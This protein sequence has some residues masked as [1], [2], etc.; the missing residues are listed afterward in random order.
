MTE[1]ITIR[2][3]SINAS[4]N[5]ADLTDNP[6]CTLK[7]YLKTKIGN[8]YEFIESGESSLIIGFIKSIDLHK[9]ETLNRIADEL[10]PV[11]KYISRKI[12]GPEY[13]PVPIIL[14]G[15]ENIIE[16]YP[17]TINKTQR[18]E[19]TQLNKKRLK[20]L[21]LDPR[22][23][24]WDSSIWNRY[25]P[26]GITDELAKTFM[27]RFFKIL[28]ETI[29]N[30]NNG[31]YKTVVAREFLELQTRLMLNSYLTSVKK[32][33]HAESV[34]PFAFHSETQ[35]QQKTKDKLGDIKE[36]I[37]DIEWPSTA[38]SI[39]NWEWNFLLV[40]DYGKSGLIC[41]DDSKS[42]NKNEIIS[43]LIDDYLSVKDK[44]GKLLL[45]IEATIT[46]I[47]N[48]EN[49]RDGRSFT[50]DFENYYTDTTEESGKMYDIIL[51]DY[52]LNEPN[53]PNSL[54]NREFGS[55][56]LE[57]I[58]ENKNIKEN[59]GPHGK[60]WIF[61]I[62]V[63]SHAMT[64]EL[65][66]KGI[67]YHQEYWKL[68]SGADP[69]NMPCLFTYKLFSFMH[70]Q[71]LSVPNLFL[72]VC[73]EMGDAQKDISIAAKKFYPKFV[74][75]HTAYDTLRK[76]KIKRSAFAESLYD[77][78]NKITAGKSLSPQFYD[79]LL[80]LILLV[81]H[82]SGA[83][84]N[85]MWEEYSFIKD[86]LGDQKFPKYQLGK[87]KKEVSVEALLKKIVEYIVDINP[88]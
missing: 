72:K 32:G 87:K 34:I 82:G 37:K 83:E 76:D 3:C 5:T 48:T 40:D 58:A 75:L 71:L 30:I 80:H 41:Y 67:G 6:F 43:N 65:Q 25:V 29:G 9:K 47:P 8:K 20:E 33:G 57:K 38:P 64:D 27:Q 19:L 63:F 15:L 78:V 7:E 28:D 45:K 54:R 17:D 60:F 4:G 16:L 13:N 39:N 50:R 11:S 42:F 62:S 81:A 21:N 66:Q 73:E 35:M 22:F 59:K 88:K 10:R 77:Q 55:E 79:H 68:S 70:L 85:E 46:P 74:R 51:L 31:L 44:N 12:E 24:Y 69:V 52:L 14:I 53:D 56:I 84:A 61:P 18:E 86:Y 23:L 49:R 36:A 26:I 1:Q 2:F